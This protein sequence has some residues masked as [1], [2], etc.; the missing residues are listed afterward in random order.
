MNPEKTKIWRMRGKKERGR[1]SN[2]CLTRVPEGAREN[3]EE[4]RYTRVTL[5]DVKTKR[6]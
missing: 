2:M 1:V 4:A 6:S 3:E 5:K